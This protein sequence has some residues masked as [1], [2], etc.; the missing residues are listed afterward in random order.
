LKIVTAYF[1]YSNNGSCLT[2]Q[3]LLETPDDSENIT[4]Q[5]ATRSPFYQNR[6]PPKAV[7][8]AQQAF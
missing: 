1:K 6:L 2:L 7:L 3:K 5:A 4:F 8:P